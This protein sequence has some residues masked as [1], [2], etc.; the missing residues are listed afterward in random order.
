MNWKNIKVPGEKE[1]KENTD[2][3]KK[4]KAGAIGGYKRR[5]RR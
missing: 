1:H 5:A 4:S 3:M 2:M